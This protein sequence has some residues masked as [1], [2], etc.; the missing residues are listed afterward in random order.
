VSSPEA[1]LRFFLRWLDCKFTTG[2]FFVRCTG[3]QCNWLGEFL[4]I[5]DVFGHAIEQRTC[6]GHQVIHDLFLARQFLFTCRER[7]ATGRL[8]LDELVQRGCF[9][10]QLG[11]VPLEQRDLCTVVG[12]ALRIE[13][14]VQRTI[15]NCIRRGRAVQPG[16]DK[17]LGGVRLI[18]VH[19]SRACHPILI[20]CRA[21]RTSTLLGIAAV[22]LRS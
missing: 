8:L 3:R 15:G 18:C 19:S 13:H 11:Q 2:L 4:R 14:S 7:V 6:L 17:L 21:V 5:A 16:E 12:S 1:E 22:S 20:V 10:F 9:A